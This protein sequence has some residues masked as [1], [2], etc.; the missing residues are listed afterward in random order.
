MNFIATFVIILSS[1][2][3]LIRDEFYADKRTKLN[4]RISRVVYALVCLSCIALLYNWHSEQKQAER[5]QNEVV[6]T[7]SAVHDGFHNTEQHLTNISSNLLP[8]VPLTFEYYVNGTAIRPSTSNV[9]HATTGDR[10]IETAVVMLP[11]REE[12]KNILITARNRGHDQARDA[13]LTA[14]IP[15][16]PEI[17]FSQGWQPIGFLTKTPDGIK[18]DNS[19]NS[20]IYLVG[21]PVHPAGYISG[22]PIQFT[23]QTNT[24]VTTRIYVEAMASGAEKK[25]LDLIMVFNP[26]ATNV[27]QP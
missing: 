21:S 9:I 27:F 4:R 22:P 18:D 11:N 25:R 17:G 6:G 23:A 15:N 24:V 13:S 7:R 12:K 16:L 10:W 20:A 26:E 8:S 14:R 1:L 5:L 19:M 2:G 3:L